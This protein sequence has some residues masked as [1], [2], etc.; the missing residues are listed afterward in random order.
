MPSHSRKTGTAGHQSFPE[1]LDAHRPGAVEWGG[2]GQEKLHSASSVQ[3][4]C[5]AIPRRH[6]KI[7]GE[8]ER[9]IHNR[10]RSGGIIFAGYLGSASINGIH[11]S[12][13]SSGAEG[14]LRTQNELLFFSI[15]PQE[16]GTVS[17]DWGGLTLKTT[18][19][20][21]A[22]QFRFTVHAK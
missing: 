22:L 3:R 17:G 13:G 10:S 6:S 5:S 7:I 19:E 20:H 8:R 9:I 11:S 18:S 21:A 1:F 4:N 15:L 16:G 12:E 14:V 2:D